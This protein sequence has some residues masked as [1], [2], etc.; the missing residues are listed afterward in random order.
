MHDARRVDAVHEVALESP[1]EAYQQRA[2]VHSRCEP[3]AA[4]RGRSQMALT[5]NLVILFC[6]PSLMDAPFA[7]APAGFLPFLVVFATKHSTFRFPELRSLAFMF[8]VPDLK[9]VY[10]DDGFIQ[11]DVKLER[12]GVKRQLPSAEASSAA[13]ID[14]STTAHT[15]QD[16]EQQNP[17]VIV[18]LP[19]VDVAQRLASRSVGI[20]YECNLRFFL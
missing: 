2:V 19:S 9:F 11:K 20:K 13:N 4:P 1:Q 18:Y 5:R 6:N 17:Y 16:Y 12:K 7:S 8:G 10:D 14:D 3:I 15:K